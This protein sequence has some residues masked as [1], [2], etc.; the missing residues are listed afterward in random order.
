MPR[1]RDAILLSFPLNQIVLIF[2]IWRGF[3]L[4]HN[5]LSFPSY[6]SWSFCFFFLCR[7]PSFI[8]YGLP[9]EV[10]KYLQ[11]HQKQ[12]YCSDLEK[13]L[14]KLLLCVDIRSEPFGTT[15]GSSG[16]SLASG[17]WFSK[18][19]WLKICGIPK[20]PLMDLPIQ[21]AENLANKE[22]PEIHQ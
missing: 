15:S 9:F 22:I 12:W 4:C 8:I 21:M 1:E 6:F 7:S 20:L 17:C 19:A 18:V 5:L 3:C 11:G 2:C 13:L 10:K 14:K 16:V